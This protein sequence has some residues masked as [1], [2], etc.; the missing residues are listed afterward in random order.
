MMKKPLWQPTQERC[1]QSNMKRYM[2]YV[3]ERENIEIKDYADLYQWSVDERAAF[4]ASIWDFCGVKASQPYEEV[5]RNGDDML[6]SRWFEG[7]RFNFAENL[8]RHKG[9]E[10]AMHFRNESG[11]ERQ[12]TYDQLHA[13]VAKLAAA[14]RAQGVKAGD[15]V[16]GYLPNLPEATIAMLATT[17]IGA[18]WSSTSPDFGHRGVLD[19]FGQIEPVVLFTADG[20]FYK[21]K[22]IDSRSK[23]PAI[24]DEIPSV[25]KV[26]VI[27][28]VEENPDISGVPKSVL[29]DD[30]L[31]GDAGELEFE[32]LPFNHPVYIMYSSGTTGVPK[33]IVHGAGGTLLQHLKEHVLH[34]D[35]KEGDPFFYFTTCGWMMW[36]WL[37]TGLA[38]KAKLLLFD[39]NPFYPGPEVLWKFAEDTKMKFFGTSAKYLAALEKAGVKPRESFNVDSIQAILSTG[40][41]LSG[42]SFEYVY[43]DI[44]DDVH[45]ASIAGGTDLISCFVLGNPMLPVYREEIQCRGLGMKVDAW[46]EEGSSLRNEKGELVCRAS[47]P[48]QP[49]YFWKDEDQK[50]YRGAYFEHYDNIWRHGDFIEITDRD[51]IIIYGR[52]DATLN[53]GGVRIGTAEIYRAIDPLPEVLDGL[54]VGRPLGDD[55]QVLLF[56]KMTEG[57]SLD[58]EL[59]AK[60]KKTIRKETTPR[61]V[62]ALVIQ[63][64]DIPYTIS[65]KKVELAVRRLLMGLSVPNRDALANPDAL[66]HFKNLKQLE[67]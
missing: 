41:P 55:V 39:G 29:W 8:M 25:Q 65:G 10:V 52:S 21:A 5:L 56:V 27:P 51:G 38:S 37:V 64:A 13:S 43:R 61:H 66:E 47:F 20:Y 9:P 50:R 34:V 46:G 42:A 12:V 26:V 63:V 11:T 60:I 59:T 7:A 31:V 48:S 18:I 3:Q 1:D 54:V 24:I 62:P 17:S 32:Q 57:H 6:G 67:G 4:W 2:A 49:I 45:L 35:L 53:P 15:R 44:K 30:F 33:C 19:R 14:L 22:P 23:I 40:S 58:D 36:N 16:A 28:Y